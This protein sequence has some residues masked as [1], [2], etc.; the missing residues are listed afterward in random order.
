MLFYVCLQA[1]ETV[2]KIFD[3][4]PGTVSFGTFDLLGNLRLISE[5]TIV[6]ISV[7]AKQERREVKS[8]VGV[9]FLCSIDD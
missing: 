2:G 7:I 9:L 1:F 6:Q 3:I 5:I 4:C 8:K